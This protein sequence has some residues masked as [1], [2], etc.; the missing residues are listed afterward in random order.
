M[1]VRVG[2]EEVKCPKCGAEVGARCRT[3]TG[4]N[5]TTDLH[6]ARWEARYPQSFS[7]RR[8]AGKAGSES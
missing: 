1:E 6:E 7:P 8:R 4:T 2:P 3:T 5:K